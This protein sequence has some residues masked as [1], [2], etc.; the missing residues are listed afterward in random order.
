MNKKSNKLIWANNLFFA[1]W[2]N[3]CVLQMKNEGRNV[4]WC[5]GRA[6]VFPFNKIFSIFSISL[7]VC[8]CCF[9]HPMANGM[10][11]AGRRGPF[12]R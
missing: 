6:V 7:L 4:M 11:G 2:V 1:D 8:K 9:L 3:Y 10:V 12:G 5:S